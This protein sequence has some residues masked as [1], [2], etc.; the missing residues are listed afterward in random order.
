MRSEWNIAV[1]GV[2]LGSLLLLP[3]C[4]ERKELIT[5]AQ[6]GRVTM[7]IS[8]RG[9]EGDLNTQDALPSLE[10]GWHVR[11]EVRMERDEEKHVLEAKRSFPPGAQLPSTFAA[12]TEASPSRY[13]AFP[14]QVRIERRP[15]G[16]YYHFRREYQPRRFAYLDFWREMYLENDD[17]EELSNKDVEE[18]TP[19]Q[20]RKLL[21]AFVSFEGRKRLEF[22]RD[23]LAESDPDLPQDCY[24]RGRQALLE[25]FKADDLWAPVEE[26]VQSEPADSRDAALEVYAEQVIARAEGAFLQV[27][28]E[29]AGYNAYD[30][31]ELEAAY[32]RAKQSLAIT[33]ELASQHFE[34]TVVLPGKVVAHNGDEL[35][36]DGE[37]SWGFGGQYLLDRPHVLMATSRVAPDGKTEPK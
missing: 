29:Y 24:L 12:S 4:L 36:E 31:A 11:R 3:G 23:A 8:Y 33:E 19:E 28:K 18:L 1:V 14:T 21:E 35:D 34:I 10:S 22:Y 16:V 2:V 26:I 6:D 20:R 32:D 7:E 5:V 30:L 9:S 17:V 13:L 37:V 15:D 25:V 27:M